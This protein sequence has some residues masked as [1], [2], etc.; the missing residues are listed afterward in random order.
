MPHADDDVYAYGLSMALTK[1]VAPATVGLYSSCRSRIAVI[2]KHLESHM[3]K[4]SERLKKKHG[5]RPATL[6]S[7]LAV[8]VTTMLFCR[9]HYS[10]IHRKRKDVRFVFIRFNAWHFAGSDKLW[11]GLVMRLCEDLQDHF[12]SFLLSVFRACQDTRPSARWTKATG[13]WTPKMF[14][15]LPLWLVAILLIL[16]IAGLLT[17][18]FLAGMPSGKT[19]D[20]GVST[21]EGLVIATLGLPAIGVIRFTVMVGKNLMMSQDYTIRRKMD[22]SQMSEQLGFMSDVKKEID[23]LVHFIHFM[24][25]YEK[26]RIRVVLEITDLDRCPPTKVT[27]VLD[28][29]HILLSGEHIPFISILALDP[30]VI[31]HMVEG[32]GFQEDNGYE[33]LDRIVTLPFTVPKM[34]GGTKLQV[35]RNILEGQSELFDE[36]EEEEEEASASIVTDKISTDSSYHL[37]NIQVGRGDDAALRKRGKNLTAEA[38]R[39]LTGS[40]R[41]HRFVT[42]NTLHMRRIVN[43]IRVSV[44][45]MERRCQQLPSAESLVSWVLLANYWPC[46]L[47]WILQ[48]VEDAEQRANTDNPEK[49]L[50]DVFQE[51]RLELHMMKG[52]VGSLLALDGDPELFEQFLS[53]EFPFTIQQAKELLRHTVNLNRALKAELAT[54]LG[55]RAL[56]DATKMLVPLPCGM[57]LKM[58][59]EEICRQIDKLGFAEDNADKYK[60]AIKQN[61]MDGQVLFYSSNEEIKSALQMPMGDW[62]KFSIRFLRRKPMEMPTWPATSVKD[63]RCASA[64]SIGNLKDI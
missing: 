33:F 64:S 46:R 17:L 48:R 34:P 11:A 23:T 13:D 39:F 27:G 2:L 10:E 58:D 31:A 18:F 43:S 20:Q 61:Q 37:I 8:I 59:V 49:K 1:V 62:T 3:N 19:G 38:L 57:L 16:V 4:E 55:S 47:S 52:R 45:I 35:L 51:S 36:D 21:F 40:G 54:S 30:R 28:A 7:S 53:R 42:D 22:K 26:R 14:L 50:W 56:A 15:C 25:V 29:I 9:P 32:F 41:L 6:C 44:R 60:E 5:A 63:T 12:G 24:E